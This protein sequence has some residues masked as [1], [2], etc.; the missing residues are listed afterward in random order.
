M[1]SHYSSLFKIYN[2]EFLSQS[3]KRGLIDA[4]NLSIAGDGTPFITSARE[5]KH[6]FTKMW[7][8]RLYHILM[9]QHLDAWDLPFE[10]ALRKLI[11]Q[12]A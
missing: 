6:R 4:P 5:R 8:Y 2:K 3:A 9:L 10:S 1:T 12:T 11:L 7:Y